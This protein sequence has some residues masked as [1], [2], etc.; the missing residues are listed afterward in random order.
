MNLQ[1][2]KA[3]FEGFTESLENTPNENQWE[4]I[5]NRVKEIDGQTITERVYID[6]YIPYF[7]YRYP[8]HYN[9]WITYACSDV[10]SYTS[11]SSGSDGVKTNNE[12]QNILNTNKEFDSYQAMYTLGKAEFTC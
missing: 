6:K 12:N 8:Y 5:K 1:E 4:R 9:P 11:G 7:P 3:W 10:T 2:F